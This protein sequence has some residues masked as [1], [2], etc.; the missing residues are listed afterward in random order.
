[1]N[2]LV[3]TSINFSMTWELST[4]PSG[5]SLRRW[6]G[7]VPADSINQLVNVLWPN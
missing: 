2:Y 1:M 6:I 3:L 5:L 7:T 4:V